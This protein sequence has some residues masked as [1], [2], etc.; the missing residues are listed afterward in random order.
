MMRCL[1]VDDEELGRE[2]L[3]CFL[4]EYAETIDLA[5]DGAEAV[6]LFEQALKNQN[7]YKFVC[8]DILMPVMDGQA[9]LRQMRKLEHEAGVAE[10]QEAIIVMATA[11]NTL[12][13]IQEALWR[14]DCN[15]YLVKPVLKEDLVSLLKKY[16]LTG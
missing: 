5:C 7:P 6:A 11:V 10:G 1:I 16:R 9:A 15:N 8:L 13:D 2:L 14:G 12:S 4:S 3:K